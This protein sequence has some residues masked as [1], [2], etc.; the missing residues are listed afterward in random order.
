MPL[1]SKNIDFQYIGKVSKNVLALSFWQSD[2]A[3][4]SCSKLFATPLNLRL[5]DYAHCRYFRHSSNYYKQRCNSKIFLSSSI[6]HAPLHWKTEFHYYYD[7]PDLQSLQL[8]Y[9]YP[10]AFRFENLVT[11]WIRLPFLKA[12]TQD[13]IDIIKVSFISMYR[14][15]TII[16]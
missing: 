3:V 7:A 4:L 14:I 15:G 2:N 5:V 13:T 1:Y 10:N 9:F 12:I 11:F 16:I 8:S 6:W